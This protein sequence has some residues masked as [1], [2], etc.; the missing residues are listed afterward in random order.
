M[1]LSDSEIKR[2]IQTGSIKILPEFDEKDIRPA[3]IRLHLTNELLIPTSHRVDLTISKELPHMKKPIQSEGFVL[4]PGMFVLAATKE[5]VQ[6]PRDII[7]KVDG[8]STIA[9]LGMIVHCSSDIIDGNYEEP[10]SI[11]LELRNVGV[12][13]IVLKPDIPIAMLMFHQ[14]SHPIE[15]KSQSQYR[16]QDSVVGPNLKEQ[17]E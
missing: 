14:L 4:A 7:A 10:R 12:H 11:V 16:N 3:G 13:D 15:Q 17:L 2:Q 1:I 6:V 8:R 9:R 5:S